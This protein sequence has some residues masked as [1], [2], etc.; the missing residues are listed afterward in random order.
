MKALQDLVDDDA[1]ALV[2][3]RLL[4]DPEHPGELVFE[5]AGPVQ[6]DIRGG[7]RQPLTPPGQDGRQRIGYRLLAGSLDQ[8]RQLDELEEASDGPGHVDIGVEAWL[9]ELPSGP[10]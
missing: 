6:R 1:E 8:T 3:R 4:G 2:D 5:G 7:E 10:P 9:A